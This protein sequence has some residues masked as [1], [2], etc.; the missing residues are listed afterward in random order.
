MNQTIP[1]ASAPVSEADLHAYVDGALSPERR[2]E[3]QAHLDRHPEAARQVARGMAQRQ[4]LRSALAPIADEAVPARL[5]PAHLAQQLRRPSPWRWQMAAA[6]M[7]S[8][9]LGSLGGWQL[10][11]TAEPPAG[12]AALAG[13]AR[14]SYAAYAGDGASTL[15]R[16]AEQKAELVRLVSDQL[17]R[18]VALPDLSAS[19][20]HY[21]GGQLVA[22]AHGP[23][24]MFVYARDDGTRLAVMVRPMAHE[25]DTPMMEQS[26]GRIGGFTWAANGLG[27]S[28]V[29]TVGAST[30]HP[31]ANE[32][33]RQMALL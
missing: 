30:L 11:G 25:R 31:L 17:A 32:A 12:I 26:A 33:R 22:T 1:P 18:P 27:C 13:E 2:Q 21:A 10:R 20:Y 14:A 16:G 29:G 5:S 15:L 23:A 9:G 8:L 4:M 19:G 3:V 28:V 24:G 7:L 6:V